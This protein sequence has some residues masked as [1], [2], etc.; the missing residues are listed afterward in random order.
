MEELYLFWVDHDEIFLGT[1][2]IR[3]V[4]NLEDALAGAAWHDGYGKCVG[5]WGCGIG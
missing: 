1:H 4:D 2:G 5:V 3:L